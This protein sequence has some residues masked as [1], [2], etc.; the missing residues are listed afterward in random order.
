MLH[1]PARTMPNTVSPI[2]LASVR[3]GLLECLSPNPGAIPAGFAGALVG[4]IYRPTL[5]SAGIGA[6]A[7]AAL[8]SAGKCVYEGFTKR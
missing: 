1:A 3:G 2:D 8:E 7:G 4:T 6:L 5:K